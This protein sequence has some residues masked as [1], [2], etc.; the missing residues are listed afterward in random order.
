[1]VERK[2]GWEQQGS[3]TLIGGEIQRV[4]GKVKASGQAKYTNDINPPGTL[5]AKLLTA[6]LAHAKLVLLN[7]EK[8]KAV[9]GV[10]AV[11]AMAK[12]GDEIRYEGW[13]IVAI[14]AERPEFAEDGL[15]AIEFKFEP[16]PH[17]VDGSD[18]EG[19]TA[20]ETTFDGK[21][22]KLTTSLGKLE[23][24]DVDSALKEA[25]YI[26]RGTY[27]VHTITHMSME[28]HGSHAVWDGDNLNVALST[29]NVSG[30]SV[31]YV[32]PLGIEAM[33]VNIRCDFLGS[34]FG[35][36]STVDAWD[37]ACAKLAKATGKPVRLMLSRT[38]EMQ[39]AGNRPSAFA[40]VTVVCDA[41][42][43]VTAWDSH[44]WGS[45]G[46][47]GSTVSLDVTPYIFQPANRR[48]AATGIA[49]NCSPERP[50]RAPHHP[51]ACAYTQ[52]ALD[53][54]AAKAG[55][56]SLQFFQK[57][58]NLTSLPH[59]YGPELEIAAK[60]MGWKGKWH[61]RGKGAGNGPVKR[62]IGVALH[63]WYGAANQ[64]NVTLKVHSDGSLEVV[65]G[66][67]DVGTGTRTCLA[68]VA[69][70]TFGVAMSAV[71]VSLGSNQFPKAGA[72]AASSTIGGVTGPVRRIAQQA[73]WKILDLVAA[74]YAV[75]GNSLKARDGRI[76]AGDQEVCTWK[77]AV[78]L[79]GP[80]GLEIYG[81]PVTEDEGLTN[82][83]VG[84]VQ[85]AEV[86]VDTETGVIRIAKLVAVQDA[87][88]IV[89]RLLARSQV[90]SGLVMGI[91]YSLSE[92]RIMDNKTGRF[93]NANLNDYKLPRL[94]DIGDLVVEFYE[95]ESEYK[96]GVIG[97]S[98]PPV[99]STG[100]AISNAVA[101]A[102][103][104]RVPVLPLTPKRVL[105]ALKGAKG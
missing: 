5:F 73:L 87:G 23:K 85:M 56:D 89:N 8:A 86:T 82:H 29:E 42:G 16:L 30:T 100:A 60:L 26:H 4:D 62:G 12:V 31:Q 75:D 69:A 95:P 97:L 67:Q 17:F 3:H 49:T 51:Q 19:A 104:V 34:G 59:I 44:H 36:K 1:M 50:W 20:A 91:A 33:N 28:P 74:R 7:I 55:I 68:Q 6:P 52:A 84:G 58:L 63:A 99:I 9:K 72:S 48:I 15:R 66:S 80:M 88:M 79:M 93:I 40:E 14:A 102:I 41:E 98:E 38:T 81:G 65:T 54:L 83:Q 47:E 103:G 13:P 24:G 25:K 22:L 64:S 18:L 77:Q 43:N 78:G 46:L 90:Y 94:G 76:W 39:I 57:N 2:I 45:N 53:D 105:D 96:R 11:L 61:P 35:S 37:V 70:D 10:K 92:E 71:K 27:G 32:Q 21:V 101:N